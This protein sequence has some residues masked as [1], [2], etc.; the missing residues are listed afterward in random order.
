VTLIQPFTALVHTFL[1][2][3]EGFK[4]STSKKVNP[5]KECFTENVCT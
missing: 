3:I 4:S 1:Y 2:T 5:L